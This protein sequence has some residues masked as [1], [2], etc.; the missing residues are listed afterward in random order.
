MKHNVSVQTCCIYIPYFYDYI[1]LN[2]I[3]QNPVKLKLLF[4]ARWGTKLYNIVV[5]S[6]Y[7]DEIIL[8]PSYLFQF[9]FFQLKQG[10]II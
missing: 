5:E 10:L 9:S 1:K 8:L 3:L 2:L 6:S 4:P 7:V